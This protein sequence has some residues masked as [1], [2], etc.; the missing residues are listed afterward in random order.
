MFLL[1]RLFGRLTCFRPHASA[2]RVQAT[3]PVCRRPG[4]RSTRG[5]SIATELPYRPV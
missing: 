4:S 5:R 3:R 2:S 1:S